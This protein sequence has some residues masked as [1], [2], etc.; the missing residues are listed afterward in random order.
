[1]ISNRRLILPYA[2]PY[3]AYVIIAS[4]FKDQ[5]SIEVNYLI[6]LVVVSL[7]ILGAWRSYFPISGPKSPITSVTLGII[8]GFI[9]FLLWI[10]FLAPFV[11][12]NDAIAWSYNAFLLRLTSAGL[13][14]PI[15]EELFIRGYIFRFAL[16]WGIERK[17]NDEEPFQTA[18]DNM[19]I[20][21][22][23]P[24]SWSWN[25]V[26]V[27]IIAFTLGHQPQ[28]WLAAIAFSLLMTYL[29]IARKDL[30][31]CI[32]AHSITNISLALYVFYGENWN[33][34]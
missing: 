27:S 8:A 13:L 33:F 12:K 26:I 28:E 2:A 10:I 11:S 19:S 22:V 31:S 14:V 25:A 1:M 5:I 15:F 4:V 34:W 17:K 24:G 21:D 30:L 29:L 6:R 16:Q 18:L 23:E 32:V 3:F 20:N 9:G 7:I